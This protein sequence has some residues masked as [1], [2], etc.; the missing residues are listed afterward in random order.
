[1]FKSKQ[2]TQKPSLAVPRD[3][4]GK[5]EQHA[6]YKQI[7]IARKNGIKK[8]PSRAHQHRWAIKTN[9]EKLMTINT[10]LEVLAYY[11]HL[12]LMP[13]DKQPKSYY[14]EKQDEVATK[15]LNQSQNLNEY[16]KA[17]KNTTVNL[18]LESLAYIHVITI[19]LCDIDRRLPN[20]L[21]NQK[22]GE[23]SSIDFGCTFITFQLDPATIR[24][25][26]AGNRKLNP[27][28]PPW[29]FVIH[30]N[31]FDLSNS[32]HC[33]TAGN[34]LFPGIE[35][36]MGLNAN[37]WKE[38]MRNNGAQQ[39]IYN[40]IIKILILP[41]IFLDTTLE[42]LPVNYKPE[43]SIYMQ[44][45]TYLLTAT[46]LQSSKFRKYVIDNLNTYLPVITNDLTTP[47][48]KDHR[49]F[50]DTINFRDQL[51]PII[52]SNMHKLFIA[53]I[54][55]EEIA[56]KPIATHLNI[57][58][59]NQNSVPVEQIPH[60]ITRA[61]NDPTQNNEII[62]IIIN[63]LPQKILQAIVY[64]QETLL[65]TLTR[66]LPQHRSVLVTKI[67]QQSVLLA[68][69][70]D[71]DDILTIA[72]ICANGITL[73]C[74]YIL[75]KTILLTP[76]ASSRQQAETLNKLCQILP[77]PYNNNLHLCAPMHAYAE[78]NFELTRVAA[79]YLE[80][81]G[82]QPW[83]QFIAPSQL[84]LSR[85]NTTEPS[86]RV[87]PPEN[88][89]T[90][91][92]HLPENKQ[93]NCLLRSIS[94]YAEKHSQFMKNVLYLLTRI[95]F[96]HKLLAYCHLAG[97]ITKNE[98]F[99]ASPNKTDNIEIKR[100]HLYIKLMQYYN[101]LT[102][103]NDGNIKTLTYELLTASNPD[104]LAEIISL[105]EQSAPNETLNEIYN[106]FKSLILEP[107][108]EELQQ[109]TQYYF[110]EPYMVLSDNETKVDTLA[111]KL[112][113]LSDTLD[114]QQSRHQKLLIPENL[115]PKLA[116]Y[117]RY[118][119]ITKT[120]TI[121]FNDSTYYLLTVNL[122]QIGVSHTPNMPWSLRTHKN[123][124]D[125]LPLDYPPPIGQKYT[126]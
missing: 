30:H 68:L 27:S 6:T 88:I 118:A 34:R 11:L 52:Y 105:I 64:D 2:Q 100:I 13:H 117:L 59:T 14:L 10:R 106:E 111:K 29:H 5:F 112:R 119:C 62:S 83:P 58:A 65:K 1:M 74:I 126:P 72:S 26:E 104:T 77:Q 123:P 4:F 61:I 15:F 81:A 71:F 47:H 91:L 125:T 120:K 84:T 115:Y 8:P 113:A 107:Y 90:L 17:H 42:L 73:E 22:S 41:S 122:A 85:P 48:I 99:L 50:R 124:I 12:I 25:Y 51:E 53:C 76:Q 40:A 7:H 49:Y 80:N 54:Q 60:T 19:W 36:A 87:L 31:D 95:A 37:T 16:L 20:V 114:K 21:I 39:H 56:K 79:T 44:Q 94:C 103:E 57:I 86:I 102:P 45:N 121:Q 67:S 97:I 98:H 23:I 18:N 70:T 101:K 35:Q 66:I 108:K 46:M 116:P 63:R 24:R 96:P 33:N 55:A 9:H 110:E 89:I 109:E 69:I 82:D 78:L 43:F 3:R 28:A 38:I 32:K 92:R 93:A 75:T